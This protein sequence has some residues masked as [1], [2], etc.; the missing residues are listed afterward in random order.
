LG[1]LLTFGVAIVWAVMGSLSSMAADRKLSVVPLFATMATFSAVIAGGF[2]MCF[3]SPAASM[4]ALLLIVILAAAGATSLAASILNTRSMKVSTSRRS[5][6]WTIFQ[7][8]MVMPFLTATLFWHERA[9]WYRWA[10]LVPLVGALM[11]LAPPSSKREGEERSAHSLWLKVIFAAFLINGLSQILLQEV[12]FRGWQ[13]QEYLK[14]FIVAAPSVLPLW[15][16]V[17]LR[18]ER[19]QLGHLKIGVVY[20]MVGVL[21]GKLVF[22]ASSL[23]KM[24]SRGYAFFPVAVSGCI[25]LYALFQVVTTRQRPSTRTVLGMGLGTVGVVLIALKI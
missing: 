1:L 2:F 7:M 4:P 3:E 25:L 11:L 18:R 17:R 16:L 20:G 24:E 15:L 19:V 12:S 23:L 13:G 5:A 8:C 9:E 21:N 14:T 22:R 6:G 10:A